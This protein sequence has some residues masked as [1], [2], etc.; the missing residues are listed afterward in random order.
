MPAPLIVEPAKPL[1]MF[2]PTPNTMITL[3]LLD[4]SKTPRTSAIDAPTDVPDVEMLILAKSASMDSIFTSIK[5]ELLGAL[6]TMVG[7]L[8]EDFHSTSVLS[9]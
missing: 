4:T 2:V 6:L 8:G 1:E 7:M 5:T 3:V 9:P